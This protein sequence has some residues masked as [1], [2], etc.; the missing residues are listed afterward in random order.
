MRAEDFRILSLQAS[1]FTP[2]LLF[3]TNKILEGLMGKFSKVFDGST[4]SLPLPP[5]APKEIPRIIL[6]SADNKFKLEIAESR[7]NFVRGLQLGETEVD[8]H[9]FFK[10]VLEVFNEYLEAT[11]AKVGRLALVTVKF[12]E[13]ADPGLSLAKHFCKDEY[14]IQPFNRPENFEI[15]SHKRYVIADSEINSWVRCKTGKMKDGK[16]IIVAHQDINTLAEEANKSQYN[17]SMIGR[18]INVASKEQ[19][20]ILKKYFPRK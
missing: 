10:L 5:D 3:S 2:S 17:I 16:P 19:E 12:Y 4:V 15:H 8:S 1:I 9:G 18:F 13:Q 6:M 20:E 14:I 7:V 11:S